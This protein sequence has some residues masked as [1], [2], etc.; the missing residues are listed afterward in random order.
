MKELTGS[1]VFREER[2]ETEFIGD[3]IGL[4]MTRRF[5]QWEREQNGE[6]YGMCEYESK[7]PVTCSQKKKKKSK[8]KTETIPPVMRISEHICNNCQFSTNDLDVW[9]HHCR[10]VCPLIRCDYCRLSFA[11]IENYLGH[12][13]A[14]HPLGK[15][16]NNESLSQGMSQSQSSSSIGSETHLELVSG[17]NC[18]QENMLS[19]ECLKAP[20]VSQYDPTS[21]NASA[22]KDI[23]GHCKDFTPVIGVSGNLQSS[24][25]SEAANINSSNEQPKKL[26]GKEKKRMASRKRARR[27][28]ENL[29][30]LRN[31]PNAKRV[32][33]PYPNC[34]F[35]SVDMEMREYNVHQ[36][37]TC[38]GNVICRW[39]LKEFPN[40]DE[41]V[42]HRETHSVFC[43]YCKLKFYTAADVISHTIGV[44]INGMQAAIM[45]YDK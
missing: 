31:D 41:L 38:H 20:S 33:C 6:E 8:S 1:N 30:R 22:S 37:Q 21:M 42:P 23:E 3:H 29:E 11:Q 36:L 32:Y 19:V 35:E 18:K 17:T 28:N 27:R 4:V 15:L 24:Q 34:G 25:S 13:E 5:Q 43:K 26:I 2:K 39:C 45:H 40:M 10:K 7:F 44:H 9:K 14:A 12:M 16:Y